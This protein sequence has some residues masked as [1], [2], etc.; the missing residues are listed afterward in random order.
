MINNTMKKRILLLATVCLLGLNFTACSSDDNSNDSNRFETIDQEQLPATTKNFLKGVFPASLVKQSGKVN[1]E[2]Y[3]GSKY[4]TTLDN[5]VKIDFNKNGD[6]TEVETINK[7]AIP[8]AFLEQE[9]A[10]INQYVKTNYPNNFIIEIDRDYKRG[11]E[12]ELNNGLEMFFDINQNFIALD[13]DK[14]DNEQVVSANELPQKAKDFVSAN[15]ANEEITFVKKE[16]DDNRVE[17]DIYLSSGTS[18]EFNQQ[19]DWREIE[20][21]RQAT[22]P[23]AFLPAELVQYVTSH[24]KEYKLASVEKDY[25]K[26]KVELEK[27]RQEIDLEFNLSGK[28][29]RIDY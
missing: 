17:F 18:I 24:Y 5:N 19:G 20:A 8:E 22:L 10:K 25:N 13:I 4:T 11:Y 21:G 1:H 28:F 27:G 29:L 6:W 9:V 23:T 3:Y 16:I 15:F 12:I 7:T 2:N 14:H 26:Y